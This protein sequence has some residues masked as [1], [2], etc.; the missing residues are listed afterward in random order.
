LPE[1]AVFD[2]LF[3]GRPAVYL[4]LG[5]AAALLLMLWWRDRKRH[6][7]IGAAA[8]ALLAL[9]YFTLSKVRETPRAQVERKIK[10]MA[11]GVQAGDANRIF[12]HISPEFRLRT[13]GGTLDKAG[14]RK[15]VDIILRNKLVDE[16]VV[17]GFE[18]PERWPTSGP[19]RVGFQ[20]KPKGNWSGRDMFYRIEADFVRDPDGQWRL[21]GFRAFKPGTT[22]QFDIP[23]LPQ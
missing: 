2:W 21:E 11:A 17:W 7:L 16:V 20:A 23:A 8:C 3:E 18:F 22:E 14:F 1:T 4:I 13:L 12:E 9:G 19:A 6:W 10:E 15:S 5:T